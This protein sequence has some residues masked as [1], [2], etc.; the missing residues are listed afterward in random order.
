MHLKWIYDPKF[1]GKKPKNL[2]FL[3]TKKCSTD[4]GDYQQHTISWRGGCAACSLS[5][6]PRSRTSWVS[7]EG[8]HL[9]CGD[10]QNSVSTYLI[11]FTCLYLLALPGLSLSGDPNE[12]HH[13]VSSVGCQKVLCPPPP[14]W[15]RSCGRRG[16]CRDVDKQRT[17]WLDFPHKI[18]TKSQ[19]ITRKGGRH[20]SGASHGGISL[21]V[22]REV[23]QIGKFW[24]AGGQ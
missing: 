4:M 19:K 14:R 22:A 13:R 11:T 17:L 8:H 7:W 23:I 24:L 6:E 1:L 12:P 2:F 16:T 20:Q 21:C 3:G 15:A 18:L 9:H 10:P 5:W